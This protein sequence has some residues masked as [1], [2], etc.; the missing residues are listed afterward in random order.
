MLNW[1]AAICMLIGLLAVGFILVILRKKEDDGNVQRKPGGSRLFASRYVQ[2]WE[3]HFSWAPV[4]TIDKDWVWLRFYWRR[5]I[6][7]PTPVDSADVV[8]KHGNVI[9]SYTWQKVT[10][11]GW[12]LW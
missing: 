5:K 4:R 2:D 12:Y 6:Y 3:R 10:D 8:D 1:D 9:H 7:S 11:V